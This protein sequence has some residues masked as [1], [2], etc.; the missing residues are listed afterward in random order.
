MWTVALQRRLKTNE[1]E[2]VKLSFRMT[3]YVDDVKADFLPSH[4][5]GRRYVMRHMAD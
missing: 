5:P 4:A 3:V 2:E 1:S